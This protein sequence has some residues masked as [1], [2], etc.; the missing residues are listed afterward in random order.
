MARI[1]S[2]N[3][4]MKNETDRTNESAAACDEQTTEA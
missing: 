3:K 1:N 4:A 2:A